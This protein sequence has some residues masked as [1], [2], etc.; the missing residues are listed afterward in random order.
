MTPQAIFVAALLQL[1]PHLP[2]DTAAEY[3]DIIQ[4]QA[5][6]KQLNPLLIAAFIHIES[7]WDSTK[8]SKTYDWGLGQTHVSQ[9]SYP[10]LRMREWILLIP[11][12]SIKAT[13]DLMSMWQ[14]YHQDHCGFNSRHHWIAHMK[15]GYRVRGMAHAKRVFEVY[16]RLQRLIKELDDGPLI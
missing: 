2:K 15:Y 10:E 4:H 13:A 7:K 6:R 14:Q 9:H 8:I 12:R 3:T 5:L 11:V 16:K 1:A